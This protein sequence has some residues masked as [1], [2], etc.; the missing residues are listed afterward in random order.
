MFYLSY[1][2]IVE[3]AGTKYSS[4]ITNF[5]LIMKEDYLIMKGLV[6]NLHVSDYMHS[7]KKKHNTMRKLTEVAVL[8]YLKYSCRNRT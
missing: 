2:K 1:H 4:N 8:P 5:N 7:V 3:C 6:I